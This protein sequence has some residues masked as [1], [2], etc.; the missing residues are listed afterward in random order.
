MRGLIQVIGLIGGSAAIFGLIRNKK[1]I[2]IVGS[3]LWI[4]AYAM[5][6]ILGG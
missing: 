6:W 2:I 3:L 1:L 5:S 4:G